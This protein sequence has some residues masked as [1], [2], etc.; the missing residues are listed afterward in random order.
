MGK[1]ALLGI[2]I[3]ENRLLR[4]ANVLGCSVGEWPT[5]YLGLPLGGNPLLASFWEPAVAKVTRRLA[6]WKKAFLSK[7]GRLTPINRYFRHYRSIFF[8]SSKFQKE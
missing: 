6:G 5:N 1:S 3:E 2:N 8:R 7:G 4:L